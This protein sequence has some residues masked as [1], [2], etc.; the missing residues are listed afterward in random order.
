[1]ERGDGGEVLRKLEGEGDVIIGGGGEGRIYE[2]MNGVGAVKEGAVFG[3]LVGGTWKEFWGGM[4]MNENGLKGVE[5]I[6]EKEREG[7]DVGKDGEDYFL[8]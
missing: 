8:K 3:I 2:L 6:I 4:G 7:V 1:E 5:E